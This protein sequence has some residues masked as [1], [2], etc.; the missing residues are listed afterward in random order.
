V[1]LC[2]RVIVAKCVLTNTHGMFTHVHVTEWMNVLVAD[3]DIWPDE[4]VHL[5]VLTDGE[6][7]RL[8]ALV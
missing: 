1:R 5:S 7:I 3:R 4:S 6:V 8:G 2:S